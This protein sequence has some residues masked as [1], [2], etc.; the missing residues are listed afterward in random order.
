MK[1][2]ALLR[3]INVSGKNKIPMADLKVMFE[4]LG[5]SDVQTYLNTGNVVYEGKNFSPADIVLGIKKTF[6]LDISVMILDRQ[7]VLEIVDGYDLD[8][9]PKNCYITIMQDSIKVDLKGFI[10]QYKTPED[11]YKIMDKYIYFFF[12]NGYGRTKITNNFIEKKS[13][14]T[15]TTRNLKT[16]T[17]IKEMML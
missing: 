13:A 8:E 6:D 3:G 12:P 10:D 9:G 5:A 16:M 14:L 15:A 4:S 2:V 17:K 11:I 7:H 1:Y